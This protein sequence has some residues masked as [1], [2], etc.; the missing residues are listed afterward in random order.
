M[1]EH[2]SAELQRVLDRKGLSVEQYPAQCA[3]IAEEFRK[4]I[5][6]LAA[7]TGK[8]NGPLE[9]RLIN[10]IDTLSVRVRLPSDVQQTCDRIVQAMGAAEGELMVQ[11]N[12][13]KRAE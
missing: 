1:S 9:A 2:I 10:T 4:K 3:R 8:S 5:V 6:A 13:S 11:T 7:F 12:R